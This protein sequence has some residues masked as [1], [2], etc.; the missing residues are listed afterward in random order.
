MSDEVKNVNDIKVTDESTLDWISR[1][2]DAHKEELMNRAY[3][4]RA[5]ELLQ[6]KP[7]APDFA[8]MSNE[9]LERFKMKNGFYTR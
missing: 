8:S 5:E 3:A 7:P 1:L 4:R 9:E 2:P 6:P